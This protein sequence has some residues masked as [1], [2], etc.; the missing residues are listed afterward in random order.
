MILFYQ[1]VTGGQVIYMSFPP[2]PLHMIPNSLLSFAGVANAT[3]E[4]KRQHLEGSGEDHK[5]R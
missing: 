4:P 5:K 1:K 3:T 2:F